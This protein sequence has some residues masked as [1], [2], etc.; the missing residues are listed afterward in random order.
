MSAFEA[1]VDDGGMSAALTRTELTVSPQSR[2]VIDREG[3]DLVS[4]MRRDASR[5]RWF[6][7]GPSISATVGGTPDSPSVEAG[8]EKGGAGSLA[9]IAYFG[10]AHGGGGTIRD[11]MQ[12]LL[13][14]GP[15][16]EASLARMVDGLL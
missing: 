10:G 1:D 6:R 3:D 5:S 14:V 12:A 7:I 13:D 8:P 9:H 2:R 15:D 4:V 11:P 16:L